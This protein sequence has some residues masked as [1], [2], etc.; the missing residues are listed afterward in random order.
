MKVVSLRKF[1]SEYYLNGWKAG[2]LVLDVVA[3]AIVALDCLRFAQEGFE[4]GSVYEIMWENFS[5]D[6][7]NWRVLFTWLVVLPI[8]LATTETSWR[9]ARAQSQ[10]RHETI[11]LAKATTV[12]SLSSE[13]GWKSQFVRVLHLRNR[14]MLA[15]HLV[16]AVLIAHFS[17]VT[18]E[19]QNLSGRSES[20]LG[21]GFQS[22]WA[23]IIGFS[24][25]FY[26]SILFP[27]AQ[28]AAVKMLGLRLGGG[29]G[30]GTETGIEA[31]IKTQEHI[32]SATAH[33]GS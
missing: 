24:T 22:Y 29:H 2:L 10:K 15:V 13:V 32:H 12:L 20:A 25:F 33:F 7:M 3:S 16:F 11:S 23:S 5:G 8:I 19:M 17:A 4:L 18:I 1:T 28:I 30:L 31:S 6:W 26:A 21:W 14:A 27:A 9:K